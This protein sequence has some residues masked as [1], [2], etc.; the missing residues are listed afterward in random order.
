MHRRGI[1]NKLYTESKTKDITMKDFLGDLYDDL[2][3]LTNN[4]KERVLNI[5]DHC[6]DKSGFFELIIDHIEYLESKNKHNR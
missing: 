5:L 4:D 1:R 2:I 3:A 6:A